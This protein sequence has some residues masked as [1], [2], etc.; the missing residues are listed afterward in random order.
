MAWR[1]V[2]SRIS[3]LVRHGFVTPN[4]MYRVGML[5]G[6]QRVLVVTASGRRALESDHWK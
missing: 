6:R 5:N 4:A 3:E 2:S 1:S